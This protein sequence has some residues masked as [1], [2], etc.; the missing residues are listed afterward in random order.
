M[1]IENNGHLSNLTLD[2][3]SQCEFISGV[4]ANQLLY[5]HVEVTKT[6]K[7]QNHDSAQSSLYWFVLPRTRRWV[8]LCSFFNASLLNFAAFLSF[9]K[10]KQKVKLH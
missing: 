6:N 4:S 5:I 1:G 10:T 2:F 8:S 3:I 7:P 9:K